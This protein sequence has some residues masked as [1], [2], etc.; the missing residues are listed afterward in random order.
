MPPVSSS[1]AL[2]DSP[3]P[4]VPHDGDPEMD[5]SPSLG[6]NSRL[7]DLPT[8]RYSMDLN[9]PG[10]LFLDALEEDPL[11]PGTIL[12]ED[13]KFVGFLSRRRF[14]KHLSRL[15]G[16]ELFLRRPLKVL[17][18]YVQVQ[19]LVCECD[20]RV[21]KAARLALK[22]SP[23]TLYEP[24]VVSYSKGSYGLLDMHQLLI[25]QSTMHKLAVRQVREQ[26]RAQIIQTEKMASIG[27][28]MAG[29]SHEIKNP[30]NFISGNT[31][32]LKQYVEDLY[33]LIDAYQKECPE[34][35]PDLL[36]MEEEINLDFLRK[37]LSCLVNSIKVGSDKLK[38]IVTGLQHVSYAGNNEHREADLAGCLDSTLIVLNNRLKDGIVLIK[39]YG[40]MPLVPCNSGQLS[41]V[42]LNLISNAIDALLEERDRRR[43][44]R[45]KEMAS[46][47]AAA[48]SQVKK[49]SWQEQSKIITGE[50][51]EW[52][53]TIEITMS[54]R[55]GPDISLQGSRVAGEDRA[56]DDS[57]GKDIT[58]SADWWVS[59]IIADNV[60]GIPDN[61]HARIFDTFFTTKAIGKGT[62][63]G[64]AISHDI[65]AKGHGGYLCLQSPRMDAADKT[66]DHANHGDSSA[67]ST[68]NLADTHGNEDPE[69]A[70][71]TNIGM[72]DLPGTLFEVL[73]PLEAKDNQD[74]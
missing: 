60:P 29:I 24:I 3:P 7:R 32:Y 39:N 65:V 21:D 48:G 16:Q 44:D 10:Q 36:E 42:F 61:I 11:L 70:G 8:H 66:L 54:M 56:D 1:P 71:N 51:D 12:K 55:R 62:G 4:R 5:N 34:R 53:P 57:S 19:P 68:V 14:R 20:L 45:R 58:L 22:R 72:G 28:M 46:V 67:D 49:L 25:A 9:S 23:E 41:Q 73:L 35:S 38:E 30:V 37:D 47:N 43:E 64:L 31:V 74:N 40:E 59:V 6:L 69:R 26:A 13:R 27:T 63:L 18:K 17:Y 52:T 33:D 2:K 50:D 15:Y